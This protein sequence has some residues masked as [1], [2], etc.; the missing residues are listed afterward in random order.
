MNILTRCVLLSGLS[1]AFLSAA[2]NAAELLV[3]EQDGCPYC[4]KFNREIAQAYP[5][6]PEGSLA[7]LRRIDLNDA[8]PAEYANIRQ[9]RFTPTFILINNGQEIDRIV[10][11]P[12]DEYFWFLLGEMLQKL[13]DSPKN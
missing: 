2:A 8:W 6:T 3:I 7:P 5:K 4:E 1:L 13:P 9:E 12:G 10:G 11:Y